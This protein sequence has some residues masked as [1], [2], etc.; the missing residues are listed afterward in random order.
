MTDQNRL[1]YEGL[2]LYDMYLKQYIDK[3]IVEAIDAY[4]KE[5]KADDSIFD[6]QTDDII[7]EE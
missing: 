1:D 3:K 5:D 2:K 6:D 4:R 7:V